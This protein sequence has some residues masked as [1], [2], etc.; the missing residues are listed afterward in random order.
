MGNLLVAW[1]TQLQGHRKLQTLIHAA[2]PS[3]KL[4]GPQTNG[5]QRANCETQNSNQDPRSLNN[6]EATE[7]SSNIAPCLIPDRAV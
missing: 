2:Y 6:L 4:Q 5:L 1:C 3:Q 7:L